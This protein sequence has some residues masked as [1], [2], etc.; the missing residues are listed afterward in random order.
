MDTPEIYTM[1][2]LEKVQFVG[3]LEIPNLETHHFQ[4]PME[5]LKADQT[6]GITPW[7]SPNPLQG[8][9]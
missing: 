5:K 8:W 2:H 4:V 6:L 9:N 3:S 7:R 1:V